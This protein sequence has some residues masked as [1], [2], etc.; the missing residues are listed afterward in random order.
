M[1]P[2]EERMPRERLAMVMVR[3]VL[4]MVRRLAVLLS[5]VLGLLR[6]RGL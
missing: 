4:V 5:D 6:P 3:V 2:G 1:P